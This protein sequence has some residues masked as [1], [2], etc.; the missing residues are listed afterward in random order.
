MSTRV[1]VVARLK[2][3]LPELF[4]AV[5]KRFDASPPTRVYREREQ[6]I[7]IWDA[8]DFDPGQTCNGTP[9]V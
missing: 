1:H 9:C 4:R 6:R 3:N 7:E 2:S 8:D 5:Q